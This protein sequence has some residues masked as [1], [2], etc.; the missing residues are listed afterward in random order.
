MNSE[1]NSTM[2]SSYEPSYNSNDSPIL[3]DRMNNYMP[4][5]SYNQLPPVS[6]FNNNNNNNMDMN[7]S[8]NGGN[9]NMNNN[10][11]NSYNGNGGNMNNMNNN[12]NMN[13]YNNNNNNG[14]NMNYNGNMNGNMNNNMN[15]MNTN[16]NNMNNNMNY[17]NGNG[18]NNMNG[19][20]YNN[21]N[22]MNQNTSNK[23]FSFVN[24]TL[25]QQKN[26]SNGLE[27]GMTYKQK[28]KIINKTQYNELM[29][30]FQITEKPSHDERARL[31][32]ALGMSVREVQVWFQNRRAKNKKGAKNRSST[33][34]FINYKPN[35]NGSN[36]GTGSNYGS[37][38][39]SDK[40]SKGSPT[41]QK[42]LPNPSQIKNSPTDSPSKP[43]IMQND[44][45]Y[46]TPNNNNW[47]NQGQNSNFQPS[48][49][50]QE[51]ENYPTPQPSP[52]HDNQSNSP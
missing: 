42:I 40:S 17:N 2:V 46:Q 15:N 50:M 49:S 51:N 21:D 32:R 24:I 14:N 3:N 38:A 45:Q 4:Q 25:N 13:S 48:Q 5:N 39:D 8:Y 35:N 10:N 44:Y 9:M 52:P 30:V 47:K 37:E 29:R 16:M 19:M 6:S 28:R 27:R 41:M 36:I 23:K 7:S 34:P 11:M 18:N 22:N 20:N 31:A 33:P 12:N 43:S 1:N 26:G